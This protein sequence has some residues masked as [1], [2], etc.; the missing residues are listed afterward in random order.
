MQYGYSS[1]LFI[2]SLRLGSVFGRIYLGRIQG[3]LALAVC[4]AVD[5]GNPGLI[6]NIILFKQSPALNCCWQ[7]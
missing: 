7:N 4:I 3:F 5:V 1:I 2:T 6:V